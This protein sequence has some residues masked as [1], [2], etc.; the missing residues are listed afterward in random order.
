MYK[1]RHIVL[2]GCD[3]S[4][5]TSVLKYLQQNN[6]N[7]CSWHDLKSIS[8]LKYI[9]NVLKNPSKLV[10]SLGPLSRS[11]LIQ[12]I[13]STYYEEIVKPL[14]DEDVLFINDSYYYRFYAKEKVYAKSHPCFFQIKNHLPQPDIVI[15]VETDPK[16]AYSR[17]CRYLHSYEY[18][19]HNTFSDFS[20][21]QELVSIESQKIIPKDILYTVN[22]D[23]EIELLYNHIANSIKELTT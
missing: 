22:G 9:H 11:T 14:I 21:F 7:V 4:G 2:I 13:I 19:R 23:I 3:G 1:I 12:N 18:Y 5:K 20:T 10:N 8:K 16:I 17:K 15:N 6:Y